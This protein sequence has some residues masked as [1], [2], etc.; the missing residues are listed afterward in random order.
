MQ[1]RIWLAF[2]AASAHCQLM[3]NFSST[4][5]P[6]SSQ[7]CS[8]SIHPPGS[9]DTGD[10]PDPGAGPCTWLVELYEVSIGAL[11]MPVGVPLDGN[12]SLN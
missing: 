11:L 12:P 1:P 5:I 10:H 7:D 8:Q 3:Y 4:S 2:W 9:T 6:K